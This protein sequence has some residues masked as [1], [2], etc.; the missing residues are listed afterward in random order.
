MLW[1]SFTFEDFHFYI[2]NNHF[3]YDQQQALENAKQ[4]VSILDSSKFEYPGLLVGDLNSEPGDPVVNYIKDHNRVDLWE[5]MYPLKDGFT[6]ET[7]CASKRIDYQWK[8]SLFSK[9]IKSIELVFL[10]QDSDTGNYPSDHFG[11]MVTF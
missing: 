2:S 10:I 8:N 7:G 4:V 1:A 9:E 11:V 6:Y 3:S 5:Q